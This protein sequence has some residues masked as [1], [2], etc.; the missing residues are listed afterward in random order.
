[1]AST[2]ADPSFSILI[3]PGS[4]LAPPAYEPLVQQLRSQ[5]HQAQAIPLLSANNATIHPPPTTADDAAH[6]HHAILSI[7]D[8][9]TSP[10]NV[11]LVL[12]SYSGV[13]GTSALAG[14]SQPARTAL[15]KPTAVT[16]IVYLAAYILPLG[17]GNRAFNNAS[18]QPPEE[19]FRSGVPGGY[20]PAVDPA[21]APYIFN[22]IESEEEREMWL[23]TA[24]TRQSSASFDGGVTYEAWKDVPC[25]SVIAG[26]DVIVPTRHQEKMFAEAVAAGGKV[27]RVFLEGVGHFLNVT[28]KERVAAEIIKLGERE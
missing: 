19:P 22:D 21:F 3:V 2:Q 24:F 14:L 26:E 6:I 25:V 13:P 7:L 15:G 17:V 16:G 8:A 18:D 10:K 11:V 1:M 28:A 12:H 5:G 9:P 27:E 20:M 23:R 4:F